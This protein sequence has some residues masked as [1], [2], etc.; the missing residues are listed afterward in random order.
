MSNRSF[1]SRQEEV[2]KITVGGDW[3]SIEEKK[4]KKSNH[5]DYED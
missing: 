1:L 3:E 5:E 4:S 2:E